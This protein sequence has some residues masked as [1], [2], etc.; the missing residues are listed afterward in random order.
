M[1]FTLADLINA[2]GNCQID[3]FYHLILDRAYIGEV[4]SPN[5]LMV[6]PKDVNIINYIYILKSYKMHIPAHLSC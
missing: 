5:D 1:N 6:V 3:E 4:V 2:A